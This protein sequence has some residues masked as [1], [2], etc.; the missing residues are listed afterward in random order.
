MQFAAAR[1]LAEGDAWLDEARRAYADA[2]RATAAVAGVAAPE[3]GPFLFF[4]A[5][6][7]FRPGEALDA[8]LE[9]YLDSP[10]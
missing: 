6:P 1:A 4:D 7:F 10:D 9:R 8:F 3:S 5:A 2:G